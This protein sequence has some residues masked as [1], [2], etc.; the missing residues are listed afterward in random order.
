[1]KLNQLSD[2]KGARKTRVRL[3]RG[4]GSG[5]G[6]TAGRGVKGQK[7]RSG[8]AINGFE[9]GQMPVHM[10]LP[11]RG[12]NKPNRLKFVELNVGRLQQAIAAGKVDAGAPITEQGL[13]EAGVI[14]RLNDGVR[15]LGNGK[16][17]TKVEI[18]VTGAS[19]SAVSAVEAAGGSVTILPPKRTPQPGPKE[20]QPADKSKKNSDGKRGKKKAVAA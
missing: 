16:I 4:V 3:G 18:S 10:R 2:N 20:R 15:L 8:V 1:M 17:D 5:K 19:K 12:F 11:K 13:V 14:N 9:G 6:K 7:S